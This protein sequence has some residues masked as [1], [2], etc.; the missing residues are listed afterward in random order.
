MVALFGALYGFFCFFFCF[1]SFLLK[2]FSTFRIG[3]CHFSYLNIPPFLE[4][5]FSHKFGFMRFGVACVHFPLCLLLHV[6]CWYV[7]FSSTYLP[8]SL[9]LI[10]FQATLETKMLP[11]LCLSSL[12]LFS[13]FQLHQS[14]WWVM[15][16]A[17]IVWRPMSNRFY[18][19][20]FTFCIFFFFFF[21]LVVYFLTIP[22]L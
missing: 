13:F 15:V 1:F 18:F 4:S 22:S 3:I 12:L 5:S 21:G 6:C 9:S 20:H 17:C 7:F 11:L 2:F 19:L 14:F 16:F 8:P 10:S